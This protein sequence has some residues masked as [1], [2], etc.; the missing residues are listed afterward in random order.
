MLWWF[1]RVT[2]GS[3]PGIWIALFQMFLSTSSISIEDRWP[4]SWSLQLFLQFFLKENRPWTRSLLPLE[5]QMR[6]QRV[7]RVRAANHSSARSGWSTWKK[8][9][10][11]ERR[12]KRERERAWKTFLYFSCADFFSFLLDSPFFWPALPTLRH[13][14]FSGLAPLLF[15]L[16]QEMQFSS[17]QTGSAIGLLLFNWRRRLLLKGCWCSGSLGMVLKKTNQM[18]ISS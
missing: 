16:K 18:W 17:L 5:S 7:K 6:I 1:L 11:A 13:L 10:S 4:S 15:L 2:T 12:K 14:L 8:G 9:K 3:R